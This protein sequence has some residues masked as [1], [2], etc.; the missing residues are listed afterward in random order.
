MVYIDDIKVSGGLDLKIGRIHSLMRNKYGS[1]NEFNEELVQ[2][3]SISTKKPYKISTPKLIFDLRLEERYEIIEKIGEGATGSVFR[4]KDRKTG[5]MVAIK[6]CG[7]S[8]TYS[9]N[10]LLRLYNN[11]R[12]ALNRLA[13]CPYVP[14]LVDWYMGKR[15][16][17]LILNYIKGYPLES[18]QFNEVTIL[19]LFNKILGIFNYL[20]DCGIIHKDIKPNNLLIDELGTV[21]LLDFGGSYICDETNPP[22]VI[23]MASPGFAAPEQYG[24][25]DIIPTFATDCY[26]LGRTLQYL[27]INRYVY[28]HDFRNFSGSVHQ[29]RKDISD[30]LA[31]VLTKMTRQDPK[32]RYQ[33]VNEL[34]G[35]L[36]K[37]DKSLFA[38]RIPSFRD[39]IAEQK[40]LQECD[41][42]YDGEV[43]TNVN[44][45]TDL[46]DFI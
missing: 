31:Q 19:E 2:A 36:Y 11:E 46:Y 3:L 17:C 21:Y 34:R 16:V 13:T 8:P 33:N 25:M 7:I 30:T 24:E 39:I 29:V 41:V 28:A 44:V 4:G 35:D 6:I 5:S 20:E 22:Q 15:A 9:G 37:C 27:L 40:S 23:R 42:P 10:L 43:D 32:E 26:G 45:K 12:D 18:F 1:E 14:K 38:T